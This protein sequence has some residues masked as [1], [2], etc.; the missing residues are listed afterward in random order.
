METIP[1]RAVA[2]TDM[3]YRKLVLQERMSPTHVKWDH[4]KINRLK[5]GRRDCSI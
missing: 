2:G 4:D 5:L 1:L 3:A